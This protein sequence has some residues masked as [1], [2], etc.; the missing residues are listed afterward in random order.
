MRFVFVGGGTGGHFYPLIAIAE[1]LRAPKQSQP[2]SVELFYMGPNE[3]DAAALHTAGIAFVRCPSGKYRRYRSILNLLDT[4]SVGIGFFVALWKL[5]MLYPDVVMSK[6]GYTSVPVV[7]AA[8]LLR[9][10][11]VMHE[12]D[13][14]PGKA[15]MLARHF[16]TFI[17]IS[18]PE[19]AQY[20]LASKTALTG[21]PMRSDLQTATSPQQYSSLG[22]DTSL[23]LILIL[24]GSQGAERVNNLI[25]ETLDELLPQFNVIHQTGKNLLEGVKQTALSLIKDET[26]LAR[27]HPVSFMSAEVLHVAISAAAVVISRAG[28]TTIHEVAMHGKPLILI[29]IPEDISHDQRSNAYAFARRGGGTVIEEHNLTDGLL[30]AEITRIMG[31]PGLYERMSQAASAFAPTDAAHTIS[32]TLLQIGKSHE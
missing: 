17:A 11:I 13:V 28:S 22:I 8:W 2:L 7:T 31:D 16:A 30:V 24:G 3:Y 25:L 23:P 5:F 29:P 27:Y 18:Y 26:L 4:F 15:N 14:V 19:S 10:P 1:S 20:F 9:I 32:E 21:I 12:S 6:G